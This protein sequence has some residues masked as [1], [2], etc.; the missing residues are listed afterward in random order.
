MPAVTS[1]HP[2]TTEAA[3][4]VLAEGGNAFDG[5]VA[6]WLAA[7]VVEPVLTSPAGGGFIL[8]N[9]AAHTDPLEADFGST[10]QRF[11]LGPASVATPGIVAG[12]LRLHQR[13]GQLALKACAGPALRLARGGIEITAHAAHL[14]NVVKDLYKATPRCAALFASPTQPGDILQPGDRFVNPELADFIE[15][16]VAEGVRGFYEGE[17]AGQ[18]S[19]FCVDHGGH[20]RREDF[21]AYAP[22][23]REPYRHVE[24]GAT[25]Y[26]NPPP[27]LGGILIAVGLRMSAGLTASF[28]PSTAVAW[29]E[30]VAPIRLMSQLRAMASGEALPDGVAGMLAELLERD[31]PLGEALLSALPEAAGAVRQAGTTQICI[32]DDDGNEISMTTSNGAGSGIVL[33]G[34]GFVLNNMLGEEDL[35]PAGLRSWRPNTRLAS[36]MAPTL[37]ILADGRRLLTGSGGSNRIRSTV[38]QVLRHVR[39]GMALEAAVEAPRVHW[40]A[41]Q[42]HVEE[43]LLAHY[44]AGWES[45]VGH[46]LPNLFFGGAHSLLINGDGN[47]EAVGDARRGGL[48]LSV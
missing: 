10:R 45:P 36:M 31:R 23:F 13:Q 41:G 42:M 29:E 4:A 28:P 32:A 1:G 6:G 7:C 3:H 39:S 38:L 18:V 46:R 20:L 44:P 8:V 19:A 34:T 12:L 11:H 22:I 2:A 25:F 27:S 47:V 43:P 21:A 37:A 15:H 24:K 33:P 48:G 30:W 16:L 5:L 14:F 40:E 26:L 35:L 17:F 9:P